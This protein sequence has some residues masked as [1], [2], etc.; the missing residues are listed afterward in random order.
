MLGAKNLVS[1]DLSG[2]SDPFVKASYSGKMLGTTRVRPRAL[3]PKWDNETFL[4]PMDPRLPEPRKVSNSQKDVFRLEVYDYDW[5]GSNDMLGIVELSR[6][7]LK[8]LA[9]IAGSTPFVLPL[10]LS[11]FHGILG[12]EL[13]ICR[14]YVHI[15]VMRGEALDS[16]GR[17]DP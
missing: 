7:K 11:E 6:S 14:R 15:K 9:S 2:T 8:K 3:N 13:G 17:R 16:A 5:L 4:V 1:A 10:T 12:V